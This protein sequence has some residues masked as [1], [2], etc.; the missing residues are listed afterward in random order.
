[1]AG[2]DIEMNNFATV[3]DAAY[4]YAEDANG[5]QVKML[6]ANLVELIRANMPVA[7]MYE[8][9]LMPSGQLISFSV[10]LE[11]NQVIDIIGRSLVH[12]DIQGGT[13]MGLVLFSYWGY[14]II[15]GPSLGK[16]VTIRNKSGSIFEI[17]SVHSS[18]FT[19]KYCIITQ[20]QQ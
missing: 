19:L 9:G 7:T 16:Y 2:Q 11:P 3:Q 4:V 18:A 13:I 17:K 8:N 20:N 10:R 14:D 5:N 1:M 15:N 6:K 12:L